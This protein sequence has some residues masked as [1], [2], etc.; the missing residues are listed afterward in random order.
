MLNYLETIFNKAQIGIGVLTSNLEWLKVNNSLLNLLGYSG[1]E[2]IHTSFLDLVLEIDRH[3]F[4]SIESLFSSGEEKNKSIQ[5]RLI[6]KNNSVV[7][8]EVDLVADSDNV[9]HLIIYVKDISDEKEREIEL[10]K[11]SHVLDRFIDGVPGLL[12]IT[13]VNGELLRW[14][15]N[16]CKLTGCKAEKLKGKHVNEIIQSDTNTNIEAFYEDVIVNGQGHLDVIINTCDKSTSKFLVSSLV[17]IFEEQIGFLNIGVDI[18][19][20]ASFQFNLQERIKE[21]DCINTIS[22]LVNDSNFEPMKVLSEI[23]DMVKKAFC[24]PDKTSVYVKSGLSE[25]T[26]TDFEETSNCYN[27][28]SQDSDSELEVTVCLSPDIEFLKEEYSLVD[29]IVI[30]LTTAFKRH[31]AGKKLIESERGYRTLFE[32]TPGLIVIWDVETLEIQELN[33]QVV[34]QFGD[35]ENGSSIF[36]LFSGRPKS[37]I[38]RFHEIVRGYREGRLEQSRGTWVFSLNDNEPLYLD[39]SSYK[40]IYNDRQCIFSIGRD[41]TEIVSANKNLEISNER[42]RK[43]NFDLIQARENEQRRISRDLHDGIQQELVAILL[44]LRIYFTNC[45]KLGKEVDSLLV[46]LENMA[47]NSIRSVRKIAR[48]IMPDEILQ[49]G[50]VATIENF[51]QENLDYTDF[52]IELDLNRSIKLDMNKSNQLYRILQE[53][54]SNI[55]K[56]AKAKKVQVFLDYV[57]DEIIFSIADDGIGFDADTIDKGIGFSGMEERA[58]LCGGEFFTESNPGQG[59]KVGVVFPKS[60]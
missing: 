49:N 34:D 38:D 44:Y 28:N 16:F 41:I 15:N 5:L 23:P 57:G 4:T 55:T 19:E 51:C 60:H 59:A 24:Y 46:K 6:G 31:Y 22:S 35:I 11:D 40:M 52:S 50:F 29:T 10:Y 43:L 36:T 8:T 9:D 32:S 25:F 17:I 12:F 39:V 20:K 14:N 48:D 21:L 26:S 47:E 56:Y 2:L 33:N 13:N 37:E 27:S 53:S 3:Y 42:I 54:F 7:W 1:E 18:T 30:I 45:K 58:M